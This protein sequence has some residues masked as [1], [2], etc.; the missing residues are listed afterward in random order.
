MNIHLAFSYVRFVPT[1]STPFPHILFDE[2]AATCDDSDIIVEVGCYLGHGTCYLAECLAHYG[3]R[4]RFYAIDSWDQVLEPI[5]GATRTAALPWGES[6]EAFHAR[7]GSLYDAFRFYL[8]NCPA[9]DRL[10]DHAQFPAQSCMEEFKDNS[11]SFV[12]LG[13]PDTEEN[14][15]KQIEK[16]RPKM[17]EN[18]R[19]A[20]ADGTIA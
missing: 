2:V 16:W 5:Y 14:I 3:K 17:K 15:Q 8:D 19:I 20:L 9:R 12:Y 1:S 11:V 10:W 18:G 7:G 13:Y 6:I 4:P